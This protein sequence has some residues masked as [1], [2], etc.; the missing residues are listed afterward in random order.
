MGYIALTAVRGD[1]YES[2]ALRPFKLRVG[3][4]TA[5][6]GFQCVYGRVAGDKYRLR[7]FPLAEKVLPG[8]LSGREIIL[9][10]YADRLTVELLRIG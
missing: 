2:A 1:D 3:I 4:I 7:L 9:R 10:N 8:K 5:D 6:G